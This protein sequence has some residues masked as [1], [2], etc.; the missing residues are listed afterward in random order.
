[1]DDRFTRTDRHTYRQTFT[2][3]ETTDYHITVRVFGWGNSGTPV[4]VLL[5]DVSLM[6]P[7]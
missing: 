2:P 1:M 5:D 3:T 4:E 7:G 6:V